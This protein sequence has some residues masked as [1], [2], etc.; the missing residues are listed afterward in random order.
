MGVTARMSRTRMSFALLSAAVRA[1]MQAR[2]R[3][4]ANRTGAGLSVAVVK[5]PPLGWD[6]AYLPLS[7]SSTRLHGRSSAFWTILLRWWPTGVRP[8]DRSSGSLLVADLRFHAF[9]SHHS[10][11]HAYDL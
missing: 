8:R 5:R 1:A 11:M 3:A 7:L 9:L 10:S 6:T 4:L 2:S